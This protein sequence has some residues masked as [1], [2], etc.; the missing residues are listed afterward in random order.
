MGRKFVIGDIHGEDQKLLNVLEKAGFDFE[1][2]HLTTLGDLVD[3][4]PEPFRCMEI[5]MKVKNRRDIKGNHDVCLNHWINMGAQANPNTHMLGGHHGS[6][7]TMDQWLALDKAAQKRC[8]AFLDGQVNYHINEQNDLFIHAG[9]DR[10]YKIEE[11]IEDEYWWSRSFIMAAASCT[12]EQKLKTIEDFN[13]I[14]IGHTPVTRWGGTEP[15][16]MGGVWCLDT[17]SGKGGLLT[18]MDLETEEFWQD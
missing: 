2:D 16:L 4:G 10:A 17:G 11:Q 6:Q 3:R 18:L 1:K 5:L 13:K 9:L 14:Y 8:K 15:K 7:A 12:G